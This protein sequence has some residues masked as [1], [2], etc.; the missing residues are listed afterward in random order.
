MIATTCCQQGGSCFSVA[1]STRAIR[2]KKERGQF[3]ENLED[4]SP[5]YTPDLA[6]EISGVGG[7]R[8]SR[9]RCL[10]ENRRKWLGTGRDSGPEWT[11]TE[12]IWIACL[13]LQFIFRTVF[14]YIYFYS[15][16][17]LFTKQ[18]PVFKSLCDI[19]FYKGF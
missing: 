7:P 6:W 4:S 17:T 18:K 1:P 3:R 9:T 13:I 2:Q 5:L 16:E 15:F 19:I 11:N 14:F 8:K 10:W 12:Q